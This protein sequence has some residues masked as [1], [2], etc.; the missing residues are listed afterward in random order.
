M[1]FAVLLSTL[2]LFGKKGP[3]FWREEWVADGGRME[4]KNILNL[5]Y[6]MHGS[7]Q[8]SPLAYSNIKVVHR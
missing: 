3:H 8:A 1:H 2:F 6:R 4:V 7:S 5:R